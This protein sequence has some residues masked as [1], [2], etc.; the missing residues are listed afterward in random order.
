MLLVTNII[1]SQSYNFLVRVPTA[2]KEVHANQ[3]LIDY[4]S[5][6]TDQREVRMGMGDVIYFGDITTEVCNFDPITYPV[7]LIDADYNGGGQIV[8]KC[9]GTTGVCFTICNMLE[10]AEP[11]VFQNDVY[12]YAT[13]TLYRGNDFE[14]S[15]SGGSYQ[16]KLSQCSNVIEN[17]PPPIMLPC[18]GVHSFCGDFSGIQQYGDSY[19]ITCLP[20]TS[21]CVFV[22]VHNGPDITCE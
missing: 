16:F 1:Y 6:G 10:M 14:I 17:Y 20:S 4:R 2:N 13:A 15:N 11:T 3:V 5:N 21:L 9:T 19:F 7:T 12:V 22:N 18:D 8:I